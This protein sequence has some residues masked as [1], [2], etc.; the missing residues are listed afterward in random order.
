MK[1]TNFYS[2][3]DKAQL[4]YEYS[5]KDVKNVKEL[6]NIVETITGKKVDFTWTEL[7]LMKNNME[8]L[9]NLVKNMGLN[10]Q[11]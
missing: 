2:F 6:G 10:L 1:N 9:V 11:K 7:D 4:K 5:F 3:F 8:H